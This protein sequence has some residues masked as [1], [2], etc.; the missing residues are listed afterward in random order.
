MLRMKSSFMCTKGD[1]TGKPS[2]ERGGREIPPV[3]GGK[4]KAVAFT[5]SG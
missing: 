5:D 2:G 1:L 4:G 3:D